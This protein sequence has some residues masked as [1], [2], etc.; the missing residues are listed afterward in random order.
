MQ[1]QEAQQN[2]WLRCGCG[3]RLAKFMDKN[4]LELL[5]R[6]GQRY[7][8]G[9]NYIKVTCDKCGKEYFRQSTHAIDN[10]GP[11]LPQKLVSPFFV[12]KYH[13]TN[14]YN[15]LSQKQKDIFELLQDIDGEAIPHEDIAQKVHLSVKDVRQH[16]AKLR[17]KLWDVRNAREQTNYLE[18][19]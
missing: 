1:V 4:E 12:P 14:L 9:F 18:D 17:E 8:I 19:M 7:R 5:G 6:F 16:V 11:F 13:L 3:N 2:E 10:L 15:S